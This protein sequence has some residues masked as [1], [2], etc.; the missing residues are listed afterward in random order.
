MYTIWIVD[1]KVIFRFIPS[2]DNNYFDPANET[3]V[4]PQ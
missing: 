1:K 2:D 4:F 3:Y